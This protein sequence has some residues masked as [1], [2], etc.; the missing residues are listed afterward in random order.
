MALRSRRA[1]QPDDDPGLA[2]VSDDGM[3][4]VEHLTE[5]R[6]R[7]VKAILALAI[8][9]VIG[10]LLYEPVL[11]ILQDPYC[12]VNPG[13]CDFIVTDPLQSFSVRL[14]V[15]AYVGLLIAL[16]V[17]L[18]QL[19]R[20]ITPGLYDN[21]KRYAIPFVASSVLLFFMGSG[22]A[23]WTFPNALS[24]LNE[25]GGSELEA[26]YTPDKYLSLITFMM[27]AFG[28]GFEFPIVLVFLQ[29]AGA[30]TWQRLASWRRWAVVG[31]FVIVSVITPS[32][33]PF[34]LFALSLPMVAFYEI[35]ILIGR[36][37]LK[38]KD[39]DEELV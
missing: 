14:K 10:F 39:E 9:G 24:F 32:G 7:L 25:I 20:F 3:T 16:P 19:W 13:N 15:S 30:L 6:R 29:M 2:E 28:V 35:S 4:L 27:L 21:E 37:V 5:L 1:D 18:W 36:F 23:L 33:D 12:Q 31:I 22:L 34:T 17:V 11:R 26:M 8:G 38:R